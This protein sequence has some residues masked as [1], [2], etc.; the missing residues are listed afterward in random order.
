MCPHLIKIHW[1]WREAS[2]PLTQNQRRARTAAQI[3]P[4]TP[5]RE[6]E[7]LQ[8]GRLYDYCW[9]LKCLCR[10]VVCLAVSTF[11]FFFVFKK[12]SSVWSASS[13][14]R[15]AVGCVFRWEVLVCRPLSLTNFNGEMLLE[16]LWLKYHRTSAAISV[17]TTS[18]PVV[19]SSSQMI[20]RMNGDI[21]GLIYA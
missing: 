21:S 16:E 14:E 15:R 5:R 7:T 19:L 8:S 20:G 6:S 1:G 18:P 2:S 4:V 9:I 13:P 11:F 17:C 3:T 10:S 12:Q